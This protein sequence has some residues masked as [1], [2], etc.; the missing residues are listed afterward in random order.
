MS[1]LP[2]LA[3]SDLANVQAGG[4][5]SWSTSGDTDDRPTEEVA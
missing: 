2:E 3:E 4:Y 5:M 1:E